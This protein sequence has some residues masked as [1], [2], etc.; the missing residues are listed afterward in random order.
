M[1]KK[2]FLVLSLIL[3]FASCQPL[4]RTV[5]GIKKPKTES[6]NSIEDYIDSNS[7]PIDKSKNFYLSSS[8]D[9][10]KL[11]KFRDT[12]FRLPDIYLFKKSGEFLEENLFCL[13]IKNQNKNNSETN[14]FNDIYKV[15][16]I[17]SETKNIQYLEQFLINS[18]NNKAVF[19]K[20]KDIAIILWAKF[21][22]DKKN[23]KH[24]VN[25]KNKLKDVNNPINIYYLNIDTLEFWGE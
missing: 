11:S 6:I 1:K 5:T 2:S 12:L 18:K 7:L 24:I 15:D 22:G 17:I 14:Y 3:A 21:L 25:S 10:K 20:E 19:N 13:S 4:L 8:D 9:Y 16:S 23:F